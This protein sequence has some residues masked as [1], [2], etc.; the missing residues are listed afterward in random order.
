MEKEIYEKAVM[1]IIEMNLD[2][3]TGLIVDSTEPSV[4]FGEEGMS[5][6]ASEVG[7]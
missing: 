3:R 1:E 6:K 5:G 4:G 7:W 2:V